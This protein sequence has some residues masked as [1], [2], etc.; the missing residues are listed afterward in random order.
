MR[1]RSTCERGNV[2]TESMKIT[3]W[4]IGNSKQD[5]VMAQQHINREGSMRA[6]C[7]LSRDALLAQ[8]ALLQEEEEGS[9]KHPSLLLLDFAM[10]EKEKECLSIL[11]CQT[12]AGVPLF[13]VT[14]CK[15]RQ[16]DEL[17]Y[18]LGATVVLQKPFSKA[19]LVR[20]EKAACQ[21]DRTRMYERTLQKQTQQLQMARQIRQ[22]NEQL[23]NRNAL[24]HRI[25]GKYFSDEVVKVILEDPQGAAL[26]GEKKAVT[27][28]L[29]DLRGFTSLSERMSADAVIDILNCYLGEMTELIRRRR[30]TVIEFMGDAILAVF[31]APV[32]LASSEE[33]AVITAIEMQNHMDAICAYCASKGYPAI[34]MGIGI[35]TGEVFLGNIGSENRMQYNVIGHAVNLCSRIESYSVG[36]QILVSQDTLQGIKGS[37]RCDRELEISMKGIRSPFRV[38]EVLSIVTDRIYEHR[39]KACGIMT[40]AENLCLPVRILKEKRVLDE[41]VMRKVLAYSGD[42]ILFESSG[43]GEELQLYQDIEIAGLVSQEHTR[44]ATADYV[45]A[46]IVEMTEEGILARITYLPPDFWEQYGG[47]KA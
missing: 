5:M 2:R 6:V 10:Y 35:H 18:D 15:T 42:T 43:D 38:Y 36:G 19:D 30:G 29:A 44:Y 37:V 31:G 23:E 11:Q 27:V 45:Y 24:L 32:M 39:Q 7:L 9:Q 28:L 25:F 14:D 40:R 1:K 47:N 13:F 41:V 26:G 21:Y 16:Q 3:V 4:V 8:I 46:K 34:E 20:M 12:L 33:T 17:C 22:L